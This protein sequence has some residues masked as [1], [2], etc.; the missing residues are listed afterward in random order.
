MSFS[1]IPFSQI[2]HFGQASMLHFPLFSVSWL[3][4]RYCNYSC[5]YC[6]PYARSDIKDH[7]P[8]E[9]IIATMDEIKSQARN[10]GFDMFHFSFSGGEP[11]LHK[12]FLDIIKHYQSDDTRHQSLHMTTNLSPG[13]SWWKKFIQASYRLHRVSITASFHPEFANKEEFAEKLVFLQENNIYTTINQVMPPEKF[14]EYYEICEYFYNQDINVTLK[15][16]SNDTAT[17]IV[18]GY[19]GDMRFELETGF[20]QKD[21]RSKHME[22]AVN[23]D[24]RPESNIDQIMKAGNK[25]MQVELTDAEGNLHYLD[26]AERFNS[27]GF[28][29]FKDWWCHA[30][31]Q[32]IVIREPGGEIRRS[33]SCRDTPLGTIDDGFQLFKA[34]QQCITPSCV[35][36]A[37]SK[38]PK[39][40]K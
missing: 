35:S 9:Q 5:S 4:G 11:T 10:N 6:W 38:L 39:Y 28:N 3:L 29:Q 13:M 27:F 26:Q 34:P 12:G 32:G 8:T 21:F 18:P 40:R 31:Y 2:I 33:Y 1:N 24:I 14:W 36:S 15:P 19:T 17:A 20:P 22:R 30:G 16:Q 23:M 37:D 7:R 25:V